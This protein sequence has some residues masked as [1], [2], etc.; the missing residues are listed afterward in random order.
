MTLAHQ[1]AVEDV[2]FF[3]PSD[4]RRTPALALSE[5]QP[6]TTSVE[7]HAVLASTTPRPTRPPVA[8]VVGAG[9]LLVKAASQHVRADRDGG[10]HDRQDDA[11]REAQDPVPRD[12]AVRIRRVG[13]GVG[14]GRGRGGRT[15]R[16]RSVRVRHAFGWV[17]ALVWVWWLS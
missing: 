7:E 16:G 3:H 11:R 9:L 8:R 10:N 2:V 5:A 6:Q 4:N 15:R 13:R 14:R 17:C 12:G 1:V